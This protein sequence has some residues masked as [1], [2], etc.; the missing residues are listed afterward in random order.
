M[1]VV[2]PG[3]PA[4]TQ[5]PQGNPLTAGGCQEGLG[6]GMPGHRLHPSGLLPEGDLGHGQIGGEAGA[7]DPPDLHRL[8]LAPRRQ[9]AVVVGREGKV[10]DEGRVSVDPRHCR[11]VRPTLRCQWQH[12]KA[13]G[14]D[15]KRLLEI[16]GETKLPRA[17]RIPVEGKKGG[18][19]GNEVAA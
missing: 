1:P 17:K 13:K 3:L 18:A 15:E 6:S 4:D 8:V 9:Q 11:F 10:S 19:G 5:V 2:G 12:G 16:G 14:G 7:R